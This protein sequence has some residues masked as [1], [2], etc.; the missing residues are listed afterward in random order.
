MNRNNETIVAIDPGTREMG[1]AHMQG[2]TLKDYGVILLRTQAT[3]KK[4]LL[5]RID[6]EIHRLLAE[7][8]PD[9]LI[10]EKNRFSQIRSNVRLALA[11]YRIRSSAKKRHVPVIEY[12]PRTVRRVV[13]ENG[14]A[15]KKEVARTI[16]VRY[17]EMKVY[18]TS[19]RRWKVRYYQNIFD[20]IACGMT[21]FL[22]HEPIHEEIK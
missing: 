16:A 1:Y 22:I 4:D 15:V 20:A 14:N 7:K 8:Q 17:P 18:L 10:L 11:V 9:V 19:D 13:C 6:E 5:D 12:D 3:H 21:Y 2:L